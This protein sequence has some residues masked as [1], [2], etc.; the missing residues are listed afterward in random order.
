LKRAN[1]RLKWSTIPRA[2]P[3]AFRNQ[4]SRFT[5]WRPFVSETANRPNYTERLNETATNSDPCKNQNSISNPSIVIGNTNI[6]SI[7]RIAKARFMLP[8]GA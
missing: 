3:S 8:K 1:L 2:A 4:P 6:Q 7:S 5:A